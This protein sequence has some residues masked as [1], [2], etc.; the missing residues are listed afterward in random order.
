MLPSKRWQA[1]GAL[2]AFS[3]DPYTTY[4]A[5]Y[6]GERGIHV[7]YTPR[8]YCVVKAELKPAIGL[9]MR[10]QCL[11]SINKIRDFEACS[12]AFLLLRCAALWVILL[13]PSSDAIED[14]LTCK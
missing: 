11:Q 4:W 13:R 9:N 12:Q 8:F 14:E 10:P 5:V 2:T 6:A 1:A 7:F 3:E